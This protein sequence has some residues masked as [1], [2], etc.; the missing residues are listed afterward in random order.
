[1]VNE[2][3]GNDIYTKLNNVIDDFKSWPI[4]GPI[5]WLFVWDTVRDVFED[6][7]ASQ[8]DSTWGEY[9]LVPGVDLKQVW[10]TLWENPWGSF[11]I[12]GGDVVDWLVDQD[13]IE[14]YDEDEEEE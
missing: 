9:I 5:G 6:I 10:D 1:M 11:D 7:E 2:N 8:G 3:L 14:E 4:G 12:E 13:L